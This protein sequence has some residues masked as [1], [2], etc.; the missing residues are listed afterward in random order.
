MYRG[1]VVEVWVGKKADDL[2][3]VRKKNIVAK[4]KK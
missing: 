1:L 2:G 3:L 4:S